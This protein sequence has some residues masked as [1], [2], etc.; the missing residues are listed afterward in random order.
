MSL[1][2]SYRPVRL[3]YGTQ[4]AQS[5]NYSPYRLPS[6]QF[7]VI[8]FEQEH[9]HRSVS[10]LVCAA[11][12]TSNT[13]SGEA[14]DGLDQLFLHRPLKSSASSPDQVGFASFDQSPFRLR[15]SVLEHAHDDVAVDERPRLRGSPACEL[16]YE[17]DELVREGGV[18]FTCTNSVIW[19]R[20]PKSLLPPPFDHHRRVEGKVE[21]HEGRKAIVVPCRRVPAGDHQ[22]CSDCLTTF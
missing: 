21:P 11:Q 2:D 14:L 16:G 6:D 22:I 3:R 12:E 20:H 10:S 5:R 19:S 1:R 17:A 8:W 15:R 13:T 4:R 9:F 7:G 18:E